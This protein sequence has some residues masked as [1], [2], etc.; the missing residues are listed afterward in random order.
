M[1]FFKPAWMSDNRDKA[2]R[3]V[4]KITDQEKLK[5]VVTNAPHAAARLAA[6]SAIV[7]QS[8]L[9]DIALSKRDVA[10]RGAATARL[11]NPAVL[12]EIAK[13]D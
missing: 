6:V 9:A 8:F 2:V 4:G 3:A 7:D 12:A 10:L 13:R 11:A 5:E 1:W